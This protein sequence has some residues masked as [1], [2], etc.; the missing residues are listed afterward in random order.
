MKAITIIISLL[1]LSLVVIGYSYF[2][3]LGCDTD[4]SVV[5]QFISDERY[6]RHTAMLIFK[7]GDRCISYSDGDLVGTF[8]W[9]MVKNTLEQRVYLITDG[10]GKKTR[11]ILYPNNRAEIRGD[12]T[13]TCRW[14]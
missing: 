13:I 6:E 5:V 1:L 12:D 10:N 2:T 11:V 8:G 14:V 7:R 9:T 4:Q 3:H